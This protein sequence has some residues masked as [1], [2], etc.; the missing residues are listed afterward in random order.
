MQD[1]ATLRDSAAA[2]TLVEVLNHW[3]HERPEG[4]A[5]SF[6]RDG[7]DPEAHL[8]WRELDARARAV[9]ASLERAGA[10]GRQ[11]LMLYPPGLEFI[12]AFCACLYAGV[13]AVPAYLPASKRHLPRLRSIARDAR[14]A[15]V[16]THSTQ[17]RRLRGA[18][19]VT[20]LEGLDW[21]T[22]DEV[23]AA[24]GETWSGSGPSAGDLAF[25]Q[26][27]SGST[28]APKGVMVSHANL[29]HQAEILRRSFELD[30]SAVIVGWL[31]QYHDMGLIGNILEPL[32]LGARCILMSP[33]AFLQKPLRW[34]AAIQRYG[35]TV[36]GGP[37]FAYGLCADRIGAADR[38]SLDLSDWQVA[39]SGAEPVRAAT[40]DRFGEAFA[41]CGFRRQAFYPCY[42]M[43][44]ATLMI[45]GGERSTPPVE[46]AVS[47]AAL[48]RHQVVQGEGEDARRLIGCGRTCHGQRLRIVDPKSLEPCALGAVGEIW[49]A[50][51]SVA[52]GYWRQDELTAQTFG[53]RLADEGPYL[54]TGDLGF[55]RQGEL[56]VTGRLKDLI[57]IRGR[58]HYPQDIELT[59]EGSHPSLR[60]SCGAAVAVEAAGEERLVVIHEVERHPRDNLEVIA[61]SLRQAV[62]ETH[63]VRVYDVV[64]I[65][66]TSLPK[67]SSG[68]VRRQACR[69]AYLEGDLVV[70]SRSTLTPAQ[71]VEVVG[72]ELDRETLRSCAPERR[73][74]LLEGFLRH[75]VARVSRVQA[76]A[77]DPSRSLTS[78]GLDSLGAVE[79]E[80][81]IAHRLGASVPLA[82]LLAGASLDDLTARLAAQLDQETLDQET[83]ERFRSEP[84][85]VP[86]DESPGSTQ[87][88]Y[89]QRALW[90]LHRLDSAAGAY[91]LA[92]AARVQGD[93]DADALGRALAALA[94]RHPGLRTTFGLAGDRPE[95]RI[96]PQA[97]LD[98]RIE[99][100]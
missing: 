62:A 57:I 25:L 18:R 69:A 77:I 5:Y 88:S 16:L 84:E 47:A 79:L 68:K 8:S 31:P 10:Q 65:R 43:A 27:T 52:H 54:R 42:G 95:A 99:E 28:G 38:A 75:C 70:L 80:T 91:N 50:G 100:I 55:V 73:H 58:N 72:I 20:E 24:Q 14:P 93:L 23:D 67:T 74:A 1:R 59:A 11:A 29:M 22:T 81:E 21:L 66:A 33:V 30:S 35:A 64:L 83:E 97:R 48:E 41:P 6:L 34:L 63:Q 45:T 56:F 53:A 32:Y 71:A 85:S 7:E 2:T 40:L 90:Y 44:E 61:D 87:L 89:G 15:I 78:L 3:A 86:P 26:Y 46:A 92:G 94:D 82:E 49:L 60:P 76:S 37:D 51:E 98:L 36:S 96:N 19:A 12:V 9:A 17:L 39:F 13:V 4:R